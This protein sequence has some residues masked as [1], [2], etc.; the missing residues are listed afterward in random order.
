[1]DIQLYKRI[2]EVVAN[3]TT[4]EESQN[5]KLDEIQKEL[6][7]IKKLLLAVQKPAPSVVKSKLN[8]PAKEHFSVKADATKTK[9]M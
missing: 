1:M 5:A 2:E 3:M 7:E 8:I 6:K 9:V 4:L